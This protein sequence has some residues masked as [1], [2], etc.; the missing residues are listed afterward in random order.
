MSQVIFNF[1]A[2]WLGN[3]QSCEFLWEKTPWVKTQLRHL[4]HTTSRSCFRNLQ[5]KGL[6]A[7]TWTNEM[8]YV[9]CTGRRPRGASRDD[10]VSRRWTSP[11]HRQR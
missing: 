11:R 3:K 9:D 2:I 10:F 8:I 7:P 4:K 1:A 6:D 5:E